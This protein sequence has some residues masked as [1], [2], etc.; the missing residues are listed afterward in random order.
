MKTFLF[1]IMLATCFTS[2]SSSESIANSEATRDYHLRFFHTHT[3]EHI[4]IVYR[5]GDAYLPDALEKL[6]YYLRDWRTGEVHRYDPRVFDLLHELLA[7]VHDANGEINVICGYR[8]PKTNEFL[9]TRNSHTGVAEQ[10]LHMQAEAIDIRLPSTSTALLR[11]AAL[12]LH[13][14]GVGYYEAS[15]FVHVDVGRVRRW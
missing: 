12:K 7:S 4:D 14:G 8:T 10:S 6:D 3:N 13:L 5:R 9:R 11:S 2:T 15:N 1:V